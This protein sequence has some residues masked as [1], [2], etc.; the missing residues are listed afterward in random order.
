MNELQCIRAFIKVVE[1]GSFTQAARQIGTVKSVITKRVN[2]LE[3]HL[4]LELLHRSTRKLTLTDTGADF[5]QRCSSIVSELD[6]AKS[7]VKS[8]EWALSGVLRVSCISSFTSTY[9]AKDLCAFRQQHPELQIE[10]QAQDRIC[11]P[12][13]EG[14]DLAIQPGSFQSGIIESVS[15]LPIRRFAVATQEYLDRYGT[16]KTFEELGK[17]R[18]AH[19]NHVQPNSEIPF[20]EGSVPF[21]PVVLTNTIW[22]LEAA[23]LSGECIALMPVFFVEDK[24]LSGE[25]VPVLPQYRIRSIE[26]EARYRRTPFV[27]MK[28]RILLNFLKQRY[29]DFPPWERRL[30]KA[31]PELRAN[32]GPRASSH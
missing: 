31:R 19:N 16:P 1:A 21:S 8:I 20:L 2:Q 26:L 18:F 24:L 29:G 10:L 30:L 9:L 12:V 5:Y 32:L 27:P 25:L 13:Q 23:V 17:H 7:A 28:I 3:D 22:M 14:Y 4:Q 6:D 11:D 15:I